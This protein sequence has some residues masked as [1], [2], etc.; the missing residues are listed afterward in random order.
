MTKYEQAL[1]NANLMTG[2]AD[3]DAKL[4]AAYEL[5][6]QHGEDADRNSIQRGAQIDTTLRIL[7]ILMR[8]LEDHQNPQGSVYLRILVILM[9]QLEKDLEEVMAVL[10]IPKGDRDIYRKILGKRKPKGN[11]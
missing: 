10:Q 8:Q 6:I 1:A 7:V 9:R 4:L 3:T 2:Q 11:K 5:G